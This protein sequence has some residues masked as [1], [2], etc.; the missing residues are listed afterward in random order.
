[1]KKT[2]LQK[3]FLKNPAWSADFKSIRK[4][5]ATWVTSDIK[6]GREYTFAVP[7]SDM[8]EATFN[9]YMPCKELFRWLVDTAQEDG[10]NA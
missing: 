10:K 6:T 9:Q 1:M 4:G 5:I 8:G 2:E 7:V 3:I